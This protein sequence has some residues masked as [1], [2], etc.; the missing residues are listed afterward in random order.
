M[1]SSSW[2]SHERKCASLL[3]GKRIYRGDNFSESR[4]D[5][6]APIS[7]LFPSLDSGTIIGECK[8]SI[9][10]PWIT[11]KAIVKEFFDK[12]LH[13]F[14]SS[15]KNFTEKFLFFRLDKIEVLDY[16]RVFYSV[17]NLSKKEINT[18]CN[19][20]KNVSNGMV[21]HFKQC[22]DYIKSDYVLDNNHGVP[23]LPIVI[24]GK[25]NSAVRLAYFNIKYLNII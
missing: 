22:E 23:Y 19:P 9:Y 5:I 1:V 16:T 13:I 14:F 3:G 25:K 18:Y 12:K 24:L 2:K 6:I 11:N 21:S 10:Q 4:P 8:Y 7:G 15:D 20:N 17:K